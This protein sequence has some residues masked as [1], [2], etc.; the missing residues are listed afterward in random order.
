MILHT[1]KLKHNFKHHILTE[2]L[3]KVTIQI[4]YSN[5]Y[6]LERIFDDV[7]INQKAYTGITNHE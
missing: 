3:K 4:K 2:F 6:Q 1:A 7:L 5:I